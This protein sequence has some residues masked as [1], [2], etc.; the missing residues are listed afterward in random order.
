METYDDCGCD[1]YCLGHDTE[2]RQPLNPTARADLDAWLADSYE[3]RHRR[4]S[5]PQP[6]A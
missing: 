2:P 5:N 6:P 4:D 1:G 3:Q